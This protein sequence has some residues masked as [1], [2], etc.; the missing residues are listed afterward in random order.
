[1]DEPLYG[2]SL[3]YEFVNSD[4]TKVVQSIIDVLLR[5]KDY[6]PVEATLSS[7]ASNGKRYASNPMVLYR[8]DPRMIRAQLIAPIEEKMESDLHEAAQQGDLTPLNTTSSVLTVRHKKRKGTQCP[9]CAKW[10]RSHF[11][12]HLKICGMGKWCALC[13]TEQE[14]PEAHKL[15]CEGNLFPCRACGAV[16][17]TKE[18]RT[19][20]ET[21]C[22]RPDSS[23]TA[24]NV[25]PRQEAASTEPEE[26]T[27]PSD[28]TEETAVDGLFQKIS[29]S[30]PPG[31]GTDFE[32]ALIEHN[33]QLV[34]ILNDRRGKCIP[35]II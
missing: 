3:D 25:R 33:S 27:L 35:L 13:R 22:R 19:T 6:Y 26:Q 5:Q 14:D 7:L 9:R 17:Q 1:M 21:E 16:L 24:R 11:N 18:Q 32:G 4:F 31:T 20:H 8:H 28:V 2:K 12:A 30:P 10:I 15:V 34:S 23:F 29:M